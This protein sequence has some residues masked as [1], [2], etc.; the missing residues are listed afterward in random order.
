MILLFR[1]K[2]VSGSIPKEMSNPSVLFFSHL[3][4]EEAG[5]STL[6]LMTCTESHTINPCS[7]T[8]EVSL[9]GKICEPLEQKTKGRTHSLT[10]DGIHSAEC[11]VY[12]KRGL[13][14]YHCSRLSSALTWS[15]DTDCIAPSAAQPSQAFRLIHGPALVHGAS[16]WSKAFQ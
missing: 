15:S 8:I 3:H 13:R 2:S 11:W 16:I 7:S 5:L 6:N 9:K 10:T 14:W 4:V 1:Y 12:F